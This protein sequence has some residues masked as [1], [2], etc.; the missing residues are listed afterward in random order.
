MLPSAKHT[1]IGIDRAAYNVYDEAERHLVEPIQEQCQTSRSDSSDI[2]DE[3]DDTNASPR[4]FANVRRVSEKVRS[5]AKAKTNKI[6]HPSAK[7][8]TSPKS[9]PAPPLAPAPA[10]TAD[11]DR[12]YNPLPVHQG[13][14][15]KEL[16][17]HPIQTVSSVL[18]GASGAKMAEVM[19]NQTI[20]H[21]ANVNLVRAH[22]KVASTENKEEKQSAVDDLEGLKKA[23]QDTYV[24]WTMDRHVLKVRRI[25]PL[26]LPRPNKKDYTLGEKKGKGPVNWA[27]YGQDVGCLLMN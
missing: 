24:R 20:A 26:Q 11:N 6:L 1:S 17:R 2:G 25:P 21:G 7:Q 5:K 12:L 15:A 18:H 8:H 14:Q 16:L 27:M 19:D 10:A 22:D 9:P 3:Q 13:P 23:R 4:S